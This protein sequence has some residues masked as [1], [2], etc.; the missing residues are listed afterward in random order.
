MLVLVIDIVILNMVMI[1][2]VLFGRSREGVAAKVELNEGL[3]GWE[4]GAGGAD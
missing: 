3:Q 1:T 2:R 4:V